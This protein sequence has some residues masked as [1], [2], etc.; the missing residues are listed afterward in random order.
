MNP[1]LNNRCLNNATC[2]VNV[3]N[4]SS[5][6]CICSKNFTGPYCE[7]NCKFYF[8]KIYLYSKLNINSCKWKDA[9]SSWSCL[10]GGTCIQITNQSYQC[11]CAQ[12]F[13]GSKCEICN[14]FFLLVVNWIVVIFYKKK[15]IQNLCNPTPCQNGGQCF[16][17]KPND[18]YCNC[19][20]TNHF[21]KNCDQSGLWWIIFYVNKIIRH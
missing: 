17:D 19:T 1:C 11:T 8:I 2:L 6:V 7:T 18:Y 15:D 10:N 13:Y 9:C 14:S 3:V 4:L 12:N 16:Q 5:Y 21:G 20:N